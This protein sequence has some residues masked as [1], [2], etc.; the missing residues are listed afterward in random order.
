MKLHKKRS[1]IDVEDDSMDCSENENNDKEKE[2]KTL[3]AL[4]LELLKIKMKVN[5]KEKVYNEYESYV[6]IK[7]NKRNNVNRNIYVNKENGIFLGKGK[8]K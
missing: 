7:R 4:R 5:K 8:E 3:Y 2:Y 6:Q 1:L